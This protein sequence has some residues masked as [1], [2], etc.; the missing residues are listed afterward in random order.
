MFRAKPNPA[1]AETPIHLMAFDELLHLKQ[2]VDQELAARGDTELYALKEK[3]ILLASVQGISLPELFGQKP[4]KAKERRKREV[5]PKYRD[6]NT[7]ETWSGLG[8]P[9]KWLQTKL[10]E[11]HSLE[12]LALS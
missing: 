10:D 1:T 6:P 8:K 12:E 5:K 9:K 7:G 2:R 4:E 3:L 11:G